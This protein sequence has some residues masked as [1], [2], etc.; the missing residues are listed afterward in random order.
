MVSQ[1]LIDVIGW[2][3]FSAWSLSFYGQFILNFRLKK[4]SIV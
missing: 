4:Y 3:Y 1:V 2:I